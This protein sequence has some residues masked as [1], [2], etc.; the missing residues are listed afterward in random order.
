MTD[1]NATPPPAGPPS[2]PASSQRKGVAVAQIVGAVLLLI[3]IVFILENTRTVTMRLIF[4]EVKVSLAVALLIAALLGGVG[5]LLLQFRRRH[6][7]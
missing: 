6:K 1:P 4:P 7:K 5:V 3:V 2:S